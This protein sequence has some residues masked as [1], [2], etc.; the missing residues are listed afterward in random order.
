M[1]QPSQ[2]ATCAMDN[3][4]PEGTMKRARSANV[5]IILKLTFDVKIQAHSAPQTS[6]TARLKTTDHSD[7][8]ILETHNQS[9][10]V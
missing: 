10:A 4:P 8:A 9:S 1:V 5:M 2:K 6:F 7:V 3:V